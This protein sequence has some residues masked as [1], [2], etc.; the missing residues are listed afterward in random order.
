MTSIRRPGLKPV[1][2]DRGSATLVVVGLIGLLVLAGFIASV[3]AMVL[4]AQANVAEVADL[5]AL[6]AADRVLDGPDKACSAAR[7]LGRRAGMRV[8]DCRLDGL[9]AQVVMSRR[10]FAADGPEVTAT[11]RAGPP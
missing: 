1:G 11:S 5:S 9:D 6:S 10:L 8:V 2:S 3:L 7:E 4:G